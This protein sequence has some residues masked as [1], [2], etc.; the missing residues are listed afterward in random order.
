MSVSLAADGSI[1]LNG[2]VSLDEAEPLLRLLVDYPDAPIDWRNC[3]SCH[4]GALQVLLAARRRMIGLPTSAF[5]ERWIDL[6]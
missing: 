5:L 2:V 1:R 6:D 3:E 4:S